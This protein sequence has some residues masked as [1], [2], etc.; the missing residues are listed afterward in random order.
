MLSHVEAIYKK[1]WESLEQVAVSDEQNLEIFNMI[2][3]DHM[4]KCLGFVHLT[5]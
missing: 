1:I 5:S 2:T 4:Q 3:Y